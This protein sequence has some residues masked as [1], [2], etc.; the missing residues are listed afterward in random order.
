MQGMKTM[1]QLEKDLPRYEA[2]AVASQR[3][4]EPDRA[5]AGVLREE[6]ENNGAQEA[7]PLEEAPRPA[8]ASF[9]LGRMTGAAVEGAGRGLS[10]RRAENRRLPEVPRKHPR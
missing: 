5:P 7:F 1:I 3:Q 8:Q 6:P 4:A 10:G 9:P 2:D